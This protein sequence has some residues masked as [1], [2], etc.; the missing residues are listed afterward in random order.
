MRFR[1]VSLLD[2]DEARLFRQRDWVREMTGTPGWELLAR[3][4]REQIEEELV[5]LER[6]AID[7]DSYQRKVGR[8][9]GLR[10]V[11]ERPE[12]LVDQAND[13]E[14]GDIDE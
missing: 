11:I 5:S 4:V 6:G 10:D 1:V 13:L 14:R 2:D 7:W 3:W 9:R 12:E 8:L